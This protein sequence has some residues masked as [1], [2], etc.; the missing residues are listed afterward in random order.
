MIAPHCAKLHNLGNQASSVAVWSSCRVSAH[1]S[2][3]ECW[4]DIDEEDLHD[5]HSRKD[6]RIGDVRTV[7]LHELVRVA[8]DS[9]IA[10]R[11]RDDP[12]HLVEWH[13][14][15]VQSE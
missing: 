7:G 8:E 5:G 10:A 15:H 12:G 2:A 3:K 13:A 14:E 9:R 1:L 6:H 11:T 4:N